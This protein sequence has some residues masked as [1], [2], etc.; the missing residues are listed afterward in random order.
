MK[1]I[2]NVVVMVAALLHAPAVVQAQQTEPAGQA[3]SSPSAM[4]VPVRKSMLEPAD[5]MT[6]ANGQIDSPRFLRRLQLLRRWSYEQV[7][8]VLT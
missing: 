4:L 8:H 3:T 6:K 5:I 2:S 1:A 7:E